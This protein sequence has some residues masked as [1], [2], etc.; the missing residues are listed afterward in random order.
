MSLRIAGNGAADAV[1]A[2]QVQLTTTR[3]LLRPPQLSDLDAW[4]E[5]MAE[6]ASADPIGGVQPRSVV[7]RSLAMMVGAWQLT[8]FG[9]F[10]VIERSSGAWIGRVGPW[11]P[12]GWPGTEVGWG[13]RQQYWGQG[14]AT[15]GA[16]AAIDWAFSALQ[17]TEVIHVIAPENQRSQALARRLGSTKLRPTALPAPLEAI[18]ADIWG[19]TRAQ[20]QAQRAQLPLRSAA[21]DN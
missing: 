2:F 1:C 4:A 15:E 5:M 3:L 19:Q 17:W 21:A 20:W 14:Y 12:E 9:M 18:R 6:P 10:S 8:G 7:W 11:C 13:L 16:I